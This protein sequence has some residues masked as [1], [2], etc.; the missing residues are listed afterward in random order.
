[1]GLPELPPWLWKELPSRQLK[2]ERRGGGRVRPGQALWVLESP[3]VFVFPVF[4]T[5]TG[6]SFS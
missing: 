1:M 2:K 5:D 4:L 3:D 6:I